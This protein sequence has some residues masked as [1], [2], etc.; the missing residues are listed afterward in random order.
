MSDHDKQIQ[1]LQKKLDKYKNKD[2]D[3][4]QKT[5]IDGGRAFNIA[6]ELVAGII[7]G[8]IIG[9]FFDKMFDSKPAFLIICLCLS[10]I[11]TF[12]L[13]WQKYIKTNI[14]KNKE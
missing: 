12:K 9:V 6:V 13:I 1:D 7:V 8:V 14:P 2:A 11:A 3:L 4:K 5:V 10:I